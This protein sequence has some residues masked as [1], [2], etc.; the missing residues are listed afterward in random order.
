MNS[1]AAEPLM[2]RDI[3]LLRLAADVRVVPETL[4]LPSGRV[5]GGA[6][7]Q[8]LLAFYGPAPG[9]AFWSAER[10][11]RYEQDLADLEN[12][13]EALRKARRRYWTGTAMPMIGTIAGVPVV[14]AMVVWLAPEYVEAYA[15]WPGLLVLVGCIGLFGF[16]AWFSGNTVYRTLGSYRRLLEHGLD[17]QRTSPN[18]P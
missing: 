11:R 7:L 16:A 2:P 17:Q 6:E 18:N 5:L 15:R 8:D 9:Q 14:A 13:V 3:E 10:R 12:P 4:V 1:D